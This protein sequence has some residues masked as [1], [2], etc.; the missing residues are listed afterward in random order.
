MA[1]S[2]ISRGFICTLFLMLSSSL[3]YGYGDWCVA[4][5]AHPPCG[6][7]PGRCTLNSDGSGGGFLA[8]TASIESFRDKLGFEANTSYIGPYVQVC[9]FASVRAQAYLSDFAQIYGHAR[10]SGD[11]IVSG[12]AQV[13]GDA[14]V[15][16]RAHIAGRAHVLGSAEV[17]GDAHVFGDGRVDSARV[18][19][20]S[21]I[22]GR[23]FA[24]L[25]AQIYGQAQLYDDAFVT[26]AEIYGRATVSGNG[27]VFFSSICGDAHVL[28]AAMI[29]ISNLSSGTWSESEE[30]LTPD[31]TKVEPLGCVLDP[32]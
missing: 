8:A 7:A 18:Y 26:D 4:D 21:R 22:Y 20:H 12:L 13:F 16:D 3:S 30:F 25:G 28:G 2:V 11:A 15:F 19:G 6:G 24:G 23:G 32:I 27:S 1:Y 9:E 31:Y 17:F 29:S 14:Q 5:R 10:I